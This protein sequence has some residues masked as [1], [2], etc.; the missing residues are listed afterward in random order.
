MAQINLAGINA[1]DEMFS[2]LR[3]V[4]WSVTSE[5]LDAMA[6]EAEKQVKQSGETLGV[7]D[8]ESNVHILDKIQHTKPKRTSSGGSSDVTFSGTRTRGRTRTR[9]AEIAF[10][11]EYGKRGQAPRPFIRQAAEQGA[12][13]IAAPGEK[14]V[15]DWFEKAASK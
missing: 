1:I 13:A 7:R 10:I 14:I 8:P 2:N 15:G 12:D 9:N 5:A 6:E 3:E 11:N 4:P